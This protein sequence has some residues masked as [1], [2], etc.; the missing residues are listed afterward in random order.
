MKYEFEKTYRLRIMNTSAFLVF[1]FG[2]RGMRCRSSSLITYVFRFD[3]FISFGGNGR[4]VM[5]Y[6]TWGSS[7]PGFAPTQEVLCLTFL[8]RSS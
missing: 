6:K 1:M 4:C 5:R 2:L 8:Q 7:A 3:L